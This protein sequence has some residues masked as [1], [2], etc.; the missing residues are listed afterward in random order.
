MEKKEDFC[1][2]QGLLFKRSSFWSRPDMLITKEI[3][4]QFYK[5]NQSFT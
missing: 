4:S 1:L 2:Q 5:T 3:I